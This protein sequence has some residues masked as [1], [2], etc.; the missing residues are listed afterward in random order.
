MVNCATFAQAMQMVEQGEALYAM[1]PV[2]NSTAGRVEEIYRE[3]RK[4]ELY[5]V[6]EAF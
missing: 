1:I 6:K 4:T 5:V 2:E 3:L